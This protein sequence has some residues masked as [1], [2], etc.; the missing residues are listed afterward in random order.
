MKLSFELNMKQEILQARD[1]RT[2]TSIFACVLAFTVFCI[3]LGEFAL[4]A[5]MLPFH[6]EQQGKHSGSDFS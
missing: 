6:L 2:L 1:M 4:L 3:S 5:S